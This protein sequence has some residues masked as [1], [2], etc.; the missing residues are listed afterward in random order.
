MARSTP[1]GAVLGP[2]THHQGDMTFE[3]RL[4]I[5]GR[6]T[7][8]LYSEDTLELGA[9]G[10]IEGEVDVAR[11]I[12]AGRIQGRLRVREHLRLESTAVIDGKLD[13]EAVEI[14]PGAR[15]TGE[16]RLTGA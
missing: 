10:V 12:I 2:N 4:R 1:L 15:I 14:L 16:V 3:G 9:S 11:A 7:G 13:A 8:R 5:D 6:F